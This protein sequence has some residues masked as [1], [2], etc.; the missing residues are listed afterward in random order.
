VSPS[1][2]GIDSLLEPFQMFLVR[3]PHSDA[4]WDGV[5]VS[6]HGQHGLEHEF[7]RTLAH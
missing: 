6:P 1:I 5:H 4:E 3:H 7:G 2:P